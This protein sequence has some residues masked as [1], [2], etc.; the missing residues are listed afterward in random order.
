MWWGTKVCETFFSLKDFSVLQAVQKPHSSICCHKV[1]DQCDPETRLCWAT[2]KLRTNP[3]RWSVVS[4]STNRYMINTRWLPPGGLWSWQT[5]RLTGEGFISS[6]SVYYW[7]KSQKSPESEYE[8]R[9]S[10]ETSHTLSDLHP[11]LIPLRMM[12]AVSQWTGSE[13]EL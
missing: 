12:W 3:H 4:K 7:V 1:L 5:D 10:I 8:H 11:E 13:H 9:D 2:M 6:I